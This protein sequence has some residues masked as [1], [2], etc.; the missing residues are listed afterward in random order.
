MT[1]TFQAR[2]IVA[3]T[4]FTLLT[5]GVAFAVISVAVHRSQEQ[6]LDRS[7]LAVAR[8][9]A[10]EVSRAGLASSAVADGA[11]PG[12]THLGRLPKFRAIYDHDGR[13]VVATRTPGGT[14]TP[15]DFRQHRANTC[16]DV[17]S[18]DVHLRAAFVEIPKHSGAVLVLAVPRTDLDEDEVFLRRAMELVF[19]VAVA[20]TVVVTTWIVRRLTR[21]HR[22]ITQIARRVAAGDMSARVG[23]TLAGG[24]EVQLAR[25]IDE[26]ID[27]L[28]DLLNAQRVFIAHAAHELR[29]PLAALYG[30]LSLSLR[31]SRDAN[32]YR[33]TVEDA[34]VSARQ[35]KGLA[36]DLLAVAR[37]GVAPPP[38]TEP[39][40]VREAIEDAARIAVSE[41][42]SS[43]A[44]L[45]ITGNCQSTLAGTRDVVRLFRNLIENALRHSPPH[46]IVRLVLTDT[47]DQIAVTV[48]DEG[49]G[50][51]EKDRHRIF[52]AFY[53]GTSVPT[54]AG[55]EVGLGLTIARS[56]ARAY[57]GDV[58]LRESTQAGAQFTVTL[59]AVP[60]KQAQPDDAAPSAAAPPLHA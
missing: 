20:W 18:G 4:A 36:E 14:P 37:L 57:G 60:A 45:E 9:E 23:L 16:F 15:R 58:V 56:I 44:S 31:R 46:G 10:I 53:R 24:D 30:E 33:R 48:A 13:L 41:D 25:D 43:R 47:E 35:L 34:L 50:I 5:L 51:A 52:A 26:M 1:M 40:N 27:R 54:V 29:S 6:H 8:A 17:W 59:P 7:L 32:E 12:A 55:A 49:P 2:M 38:T 42:T 22:R 28:A 21:A 11:S 3:V 39:V 19:G